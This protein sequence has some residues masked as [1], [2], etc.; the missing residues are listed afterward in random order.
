MTKNRPKIDFQ[1]KIGPYKYRVLKFARIL[2]KT[3]K[4]GLWPG[5]PVTPP[6]PS[7]TSTQLHL[8]PAPPLP[9]STS[10][11]LHLYPAP[12]LPSRGNK[13]EELYDMGHGFKERRARFARIRF[14]LAI[15]EI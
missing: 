3:L 13:I 5:L 2:A 10:T 12:P 14:I 8:Y 1:L 9:S 4:R 7:S 11:Q 15:Y 6:L